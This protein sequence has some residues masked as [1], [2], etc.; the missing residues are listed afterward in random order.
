MHSLQ[1]YFRSCLSPIYIQTVFK[2]QEN[3]LSILRDDRLAFGMGT[4]FR[5]FLGIHFAL[6]KRIFG[7]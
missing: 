1:V 6:E 5:K 4:K 3:E 7:M 2:T